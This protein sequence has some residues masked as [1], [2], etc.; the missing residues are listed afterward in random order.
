M[1]L[2]LETHGHE[3]LGHCLTCFEIFLGILL[4]Q[5]RC[6]QIVDKRID[7][8]EVLVLKVACE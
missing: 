6:L 3:Q 7:E 2:I 1:V 8:R 5:G 4:G